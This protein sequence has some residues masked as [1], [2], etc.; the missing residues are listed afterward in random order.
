[1]CFNL[2]RCQCSW[3]CWGSHQ[4][5][6]ELTPPLTPSTHTHG[7]TSPS[8]THTCAHT[9]HTL[10]I[11]PTLTHS[12]NRTIAPM[13]HKWGLEGAVVG[14]T[15]MIH[16]VQ[17]RPAASP[18]PAAPASAPAS[19][20]VPDATLG[21]AAASAELDEL[22]CSPPPLAL[23]LAGGASSGSEAAP[24]SLSD[25]DAGGHAHGFDGL[26]LLQ[27]WRRPGLGAAC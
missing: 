22:L 25:A 18:S 20:S 3:P 16:A 9:T 7:P 1:M 24:A 8:R 4:S 19:A 26:S 17:H 15:G 10:A 21:L 13:L 23:G 14:V 27:I 2:S 12:A 5:H 6:E 11:N